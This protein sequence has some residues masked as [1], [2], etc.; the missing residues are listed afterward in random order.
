MF[1]TRHHYVQSLKSIKNLNKYLVIP[2]KKFA[3][4]FL[5]QVIRGSCFNLAL[6]HPD[7]KFSMSSFALDDQPQII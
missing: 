6:I 1:L 3:E 7:F 5:L 2:H 4:D